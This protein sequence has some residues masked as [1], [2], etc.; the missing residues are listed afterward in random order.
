MLDL[1]H[2]LEEAC[3]IAVVTPN[4]KD[5]VLT[6][7]DSDWSDMDYGDTGPFSSQAVE[8]IR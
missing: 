4:E 5:A 8:C 2:S 1:G 3:N 7:Y 6:D